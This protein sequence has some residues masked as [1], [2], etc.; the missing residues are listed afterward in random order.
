MKDWFLA[1]SNIS[2]EHFSHWLSDVSVEPFGIED[3]FLTWPSV[4]AETFRH[5]LMDVSYGPF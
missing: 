1:S 4:I 3:W 5:C 2:A